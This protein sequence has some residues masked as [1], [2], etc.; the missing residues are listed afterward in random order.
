MES[1]NINN[2]LPAEHRR[3]PLIIVYSVCNWKKYKVTS[4]LHELLVNVISE[5]RTLN[6]LPRSL[7]KVCLRPLA[8]WKNCGFPYKRTYKV[9]KSGQLDAAKA[10]ASSCTSQSFLYMKC[11]L[12]LS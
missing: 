7:Q 6:G 2:Q 12:E 1:P 10:A 5:V 4:I 9:Q 11:Y 8:D 3:S